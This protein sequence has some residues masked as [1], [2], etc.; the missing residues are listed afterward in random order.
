MSPFLPTAAILAI[1][2][3]LGFGT[4]H[5]NSILGDKQPRIVDTKPLFARSVEQADFRGGWPSGRLDV[6][7]YAPMVELLTIGAN[8]VRTSQGA[9]QPTTDARAEERRRDLRQTKRAKPKRVPELDDSV[10]ALDAYA[11]G[12]VDGGRRGGRDTR[13]RQDG[14]GNRPE[15]HRTETQER[16]NEGPGRAQEGFPLFRMFGGFEGR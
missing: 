1:V 6:P 14:R 15:A 12:E 9:T 16:Q 7:H 2:A 10:S 11:Q 4:W 8:A 13:M 5:L 3:A